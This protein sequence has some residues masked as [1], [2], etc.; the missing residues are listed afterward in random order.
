MYCSKCGA[1]D[2]SINSYCRSCGDF[3]INNLGLFSAI[4]RILGI[5]NPKEQ[6][7]VGLIMN[8]ISF[9]IS[10]LMLFFL[11]GYEMGAELA[12]GKSAPNII[13]LVYV[14]LGLITVWQLINVIFSANVVIKMS[15]AS[16]N[17][18]ITAEEVKQNR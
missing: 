15:R 13:Y 17:V 6:A 14:F 18:H 4:Y 12:T 11:M 16:V 7:T 1:A 9:A 2:Q 8:I 5:N 3:L 10:F